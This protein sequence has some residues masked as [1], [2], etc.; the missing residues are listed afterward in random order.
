M[1]RLYNTVFFGMDSLRALSQQDSVVM[2][3]QNEPKTAQ[4]RAM[5]NAV[6]AARAM[7]AVCACVSLSVCLPVCECVTRPAR[8]RG[9]RARASVWQWGRWLNLA[10]PAI[11]LTIAIDRKPERRNQFL[12]QCM[13][14]GVQAVDIEC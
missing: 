10:V 12:V 9:C 2:C 6:R 7:R 14:L 8:V 11:G 3:E 1:H 5:C 4:I 13:Q